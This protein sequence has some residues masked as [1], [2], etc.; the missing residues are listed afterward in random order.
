MKIVTKKKKVSKMRPNM[1]PLLK[2][3]VFKLPESTDLPKYYHPLV[4]DPFPKI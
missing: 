1:N 2:S 4:R 3:R